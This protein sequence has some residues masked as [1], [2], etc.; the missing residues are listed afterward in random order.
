LI[1]NEINAIRGAQ[2]TQVSQPI[3]LGKVPEPW[4]PVVSLQREIY[5]AGLS[6]IKPGTTFGALCDL[7]NG[8]GGENGMETALQLAGC[9]YGDDGP[10][11]SAETRSDR[12]RDLA[13]A[14]GNVFTF[15]PIVMTRDRKIQ[16]SSGG[17]VLVTK[18]GCEELFRRE[19]GIVEV[20]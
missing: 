8:L 3:L 20:S 11:Y 1:T 16:F 19:H 5:E 9:G 10:L 15:Q 13:M 14:A 17:P 12:A 7:I 4:Q 18:T 2:T 6:M